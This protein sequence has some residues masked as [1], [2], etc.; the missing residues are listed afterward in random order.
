MT[1]TRTIPW[2]QTYETLGGVLGFK[3]PAEYAPSPVPDALD[4]ARVVDLVGEG[5]KFWTYIDGIDPLVSP[6]VFKITRGDYG[7]MS[8][9]SAVDLAMEPQPDG[10]YLS[11]SHADQ[12]I[13]KAIVD[14]VNAA[15]ES[16]ALFQHDGKSA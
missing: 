13:Q 5:Y 16:R 12:A 8:S 15:W 14:V 2:W 11:V 1:D 3:P 9:V 6:L 4:F 7:A 10:S